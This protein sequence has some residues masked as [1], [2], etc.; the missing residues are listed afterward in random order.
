M[1]GQ[2]LKC[3][4]EGQDRFGDV[5]EAQA[6]GPVPLAGLVLVPDL[7]HD[8]RQRNGFAVLLNRVAKYGRTDGAHLERCFGFGHVPLIPD[9]LDNTNQ[10]DRTRR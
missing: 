9:R 5:I 3:F 10:Y 1:L 2:V 7:D 4:L 8:L 6:V